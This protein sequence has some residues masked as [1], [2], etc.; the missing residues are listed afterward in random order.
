[1]T[2]LNCRNLLTSY[3]RRLPTWAGFSTPSAHDSSLGL[4]AREREIAGYA[5]T[6]LSNRAIAD[7]LTVSIRTVENHLQRT[8]SKLGINT[9]SDLILK[10]D[11]LNQGESA[12]GGLP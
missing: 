8:Y 12:A 2:A 3:G 9:R 11:P 1:M 4:T 10:L 6:G 7:Q 5:A